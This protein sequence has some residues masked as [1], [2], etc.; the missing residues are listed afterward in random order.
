MVVISTKK[1]QSKVKFFTSKNNIFSNHVEIETFLNTVR[2][3][4][5]ES[6]KEIVIA[7]N[8]DIKNNKKFVTDSNGLQ[9]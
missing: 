8:T 9:F 3:E 2:L 4:D 7:V 1:V 5:G 6:G